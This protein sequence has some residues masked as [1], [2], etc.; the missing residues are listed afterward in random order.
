MPEFILNTSGTVLS[1]AAPSG[2]KRGGTY[3]F[4]SLDDFDGAYIEALFFT[5]SAPGVTTE[6]WQATEDH[7]EGSMPGDVGFSD[8]APDALARILDDCARFKREA[9]DLLTQA[10]E[11]GGYDESNAGHDFWLTR[12]GHGTGFWDRD[13]LEPD[14]DEYERL[15]S[16]IIANRD[17]RA[18]WGAAVQKRNALKAESLGARLS[19]LAK[20]LG[21]VDSYLGDDGKVYLS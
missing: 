4:G 16:E 9:A 6:D 15:T 18:A 17:N 3:T 5:D 2:E 12:N 19:A 8:L 11:A 14:S 21:E 1:P 13:E 10:Y 7:D 20:S